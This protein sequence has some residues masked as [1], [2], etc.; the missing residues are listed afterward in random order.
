MVVNGRKK[1]ISNIAIK[2]DDNGSDDAAGD[3]REAADKKK[4]NQN[5][6]RLD[7]NRK[8]LRSLRTED[9]T[10]LNDSMK[11]IYLATQRTKRYNKLPRREA[12]EQQKRSGKYCHLH[13]TD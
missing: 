6:C 12:F 10:L 7:G 3:A 2:R 13:K 5:A 4:R 11:N 8:R 9:H 1:G